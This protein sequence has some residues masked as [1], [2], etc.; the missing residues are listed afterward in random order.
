MQTQCLTCALIINLTNRIISRISGVQ[1]YR[2]H[3][4][5]ATHMLIISFF[6]RCIE[7]VILLFRGSYALARLI[8]FLRNSLLYCSYSWKGFHISAIR[9]SSVIS[10]PIHMHLFRTFLNKLSLFYSFD[11][12]FLW[13]NLAQRKNISGTDVLLS[14]STDKLPP[15]KTYTVCKLL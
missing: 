5:C 6:S 1:S 2:I 4:E 11:F 7:L 3:G 12:H 14:G 9:I 8:M 13:W 15:R 10:F